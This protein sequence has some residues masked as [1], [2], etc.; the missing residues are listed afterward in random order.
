[1]ILSRISLY[2]ADTQ[3]DKGLYL[4]PLNIPKIYNL[5]FPQ[6]SSDH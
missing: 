4:L 5:A 3:I 6:G 2:T 1:M